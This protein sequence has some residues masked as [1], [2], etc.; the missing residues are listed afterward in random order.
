MDVAAGDGSVDGAGDEDDGESNAKGNLGDEVAGGE[1]RRRLD[2]GTDKGVDEGAG[3]GVDKNLNQTKGPDGLD[4]VTGRVHLVH[5]GKLA[6]GEAVGKNNVGNGDKGV[7]KAEVL[8]G[9]GGPGNRRHAANF[10]RGLD[11]GSN[12]G[13]ANGEDNGGK[14][15]VAQDGNLGKR[16]R[17]G[18]EQQDDGGDDTKDEGAD[19]AVADDAEK[20]NGSGQAVRA[21]EEDELEHKHGANDFVA[22][23]AGNETTGITIVSNIGESNLDLA[24]QV[25]GVDGEETKSNGQN[26]TGNHAEGGKGRG[27]TQTTEGNGLDNENDGQALPAQTVKVSSTL[28]RLLLLE[29][30][31][32]LFVIVKVGNLTDNFAGEHVVLR[33]RTLLFHHV[34]FRNSSS[35]FRGRSR[36][37]GRLV[38]HC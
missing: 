11:A 30:G 17:D 24:D 36:S 20:G 23:A 12:D 14:V 7:G 35:S 31:A 6:H 3:E 26:N 15:D 10:L 37:N 38:G 16:R 18:E 5:E 34:L 27:Q 29:I 4:V 21:D 32:G 9:P 19:A 33:G 22:C 1:K 28:G 25:T 13:D 8:L 2:F